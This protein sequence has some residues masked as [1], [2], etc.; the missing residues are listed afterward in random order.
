MNISILFGWNSIT[1][2]LPLLMALAIIIVCI[3]L[4]E[5]ARFG[6]DVPRWGDE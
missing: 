6:D 2:F 4:I 3:V 5:T 1:F